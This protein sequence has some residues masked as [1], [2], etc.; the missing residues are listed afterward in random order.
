MAKIEVCAKTI[1]VPMC[2]PIGIDAIVQKAR[3]ESV[4]DV[5]IHHNRIRTENREFA[6]FRALQSLVAGYEMLAVG[7]KIAYVHKTN[8]GTK[9]YP[10]IVNEVHYGTVK[11][12]GKCCA[13]MSNGERPIH[14][15]VFNQIV[16]I[17]KRP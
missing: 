9:K 15:G 11:S 13:I 5:P 8:L 12:I 6:E 17:I 10:W 4:K 3:D 7:D 16:A 2:G 14:S 1:Y